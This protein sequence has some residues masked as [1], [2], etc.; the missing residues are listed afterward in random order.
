MTPAT[1]KPLGGNVIQKSR[2]VVALGLVLAIAVAGIAY[3]T[4]A[5]DN[6]PQVQG[7][8]KPKKLDKKK[9]KPIK[10]FAGVSTSG[11]VNGTQFNPEKE[12]IEFG[13]NLKWKSTKADFCTASISGT[14]TAQARAA[15]PGDSQLGTGTA[16]VKFA[17]GDE[18]K[19]LV[20]TAFNGPAKN[21]IRLHAATETLG[22]TVTEVVDGSIVPANSP[23]YGVALKVDNAPDPA[24]DTAMVT[25]FNTT[26]E[27]SSGVAQGRCKSKTFK[28]LREVTYDDGSSEKTDPLT[29]KCKRK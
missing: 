22:P 16:S 15:C 20:V 29:Q 14:T 27:K 12:F 11:P 8:V 5:D 9:F 17:N 21:Q 6:T 7:S 26:I 3:A 2:L 1:T 13:K 19:D 18:L 4:G 24:G 10:L 23:G 25:S 28:F